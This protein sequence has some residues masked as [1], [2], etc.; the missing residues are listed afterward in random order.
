MRHDGM[1]FTN[2]NL[3][4]Y[5]QTN[6]MKKRL[7]LVLI[8]FLEQK[9][10]IISSQL[11]NFSFLIGNET[12]WNEICQSHSH[13]TYVIGIKK[14][15]TLVSKFFYGIKIYFNPV[16]NG[17]GSRKIISHQK[18]LSSLIIELLLLLVFTKM[19]LNSFW[20]DFSIPLLVNIAF[21]CC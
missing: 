14:Y 4:S 8:F 7:N 16:P 1:R 17:M 18:K 15:L 13:P 9:Y 12:G 2:H 19:K 6:R 10:V 20:G 5:I 3:I 11:K 21:H